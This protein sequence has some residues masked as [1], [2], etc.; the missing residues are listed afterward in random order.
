MIKNYFTIS[1]RNLVKRKGYTILNILGLTIGITCCL[2]IFQYVSYERSYDTFQKNTSHIVRIRLDQYKQ[3]KLLWQSATSYPAFGPLMKKD[4]PEVANYCRL[5]DDE[6]LLSNDAKNVKFS[7]KKGYF[8]EQSSIGM[9][10]VDIA[11]GNSATALD[12]PN[13]MIISQSMAR[14]YFGTT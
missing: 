7:E 4:Y 3:G 12:A 1:I 14:K 6:L 8:A 9:L 2:L 11:S 13:K 10:G 5:I